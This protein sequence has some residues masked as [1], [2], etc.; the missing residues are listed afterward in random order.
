MGPQCGKVRGD[1]GRRWFPAYMKELLKKRI[2]RL[3]EGGVDVYRSEVKRRIV[4]L[5]GRLHS[6]SRGSIILQRALLC[7]LVVT[8]AVGVLGIIGSRI[9]NK[10]QLINNA[11]S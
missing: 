3:F 11:L 8:A 9:V 4:T 6:G 7:A 2:R 5:L 1:V 10:L